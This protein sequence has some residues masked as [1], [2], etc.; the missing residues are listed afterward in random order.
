[1]LF[2]SLQTESAFFH[3]YCVDFPTRNVE[4]DRILPFRLLGAYVEVKEWEN[5]NQIHK[6]FSPEVNERRIHYQRELYRL[7]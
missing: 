3:K 2:L 6:Y 5:I 4:R 7:S 1:M